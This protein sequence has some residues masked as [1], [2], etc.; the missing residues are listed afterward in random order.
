V[1]DVARV[2]ALVKPD[3]PGTRPTLTA[4]DAA[5]RTAG[6]DIAYGPN[7]TEMYRRAASFVDKTLK[8]APPANLPFEQDVPVEAHEA[9]RLDRGA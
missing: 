9:Q 6:A 4:L 8:G 5:T 3:N 7:R 2:A 1:P